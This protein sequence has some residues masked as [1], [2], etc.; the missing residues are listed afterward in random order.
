MH[1]HAGR[2]ST[3][4]TF[5]AATLEAIGLLRLIA[6]QKEA[7]DRSGERAGQ[8]GDVAGLARSRHS[9][10]H[11]DSPTSLYPHSLTLREGAG[12]G[13]RDKA[14]SASTPPCAPLTTS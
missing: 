8:L 3:A 7:P 2:M 1:L 5:R 11:S 13:P 4:C 14:F 9:L 12:L 6:T 10:T